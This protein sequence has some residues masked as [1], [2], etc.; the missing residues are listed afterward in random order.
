MESPTTKITVPTAI[1]IATRA[2]RAPTQDA[3]RQTTILQVATMV[4]TRL[5]VLAHLSLA[6]PQITVEQTA[7][8]PIAIQLADSI[9]IKAAWEPGADAMQ[10]VA[11]ANPS[12]NLGA[13][14]TTNLVTTDHLAVD[15]NTIWLT[16][17]NH[18]ANL[19]M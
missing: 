2:A 8:A 12:N 9:V 4:A 3:L 19:A 18:S 5:M 15:Q 17:A 11:A 13:A 7:M 16:T 10:T 1:E 6:E 14:Q